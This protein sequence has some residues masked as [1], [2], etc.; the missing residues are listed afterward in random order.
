MILTVTLNASLDKAY[1]VSDFETGNVIRVKDVVC[2]AGGKGLNVARVVKALDEDVLAT[3]F[4]GGY[5]GKFIA[6]KLDDENI[7]HEFVNVKGETRSCL[8]IIDTSTGKH[9]E[10][11]EPGPKVFKDEIQNFITLYEKLVKRSS[12]VTLSGSVPRGVDTSIYKK[13]IIIA[14]NSNKKVILDTSDKLLIEGLKAC[15]TMIKPNRSEAESILK[16]KL[17][18]TKEVAEAARRLLSKGPEIVAISIGSKGVV[19]ATCDNVLLAK[20]PNITAKNTVG[21]GDAMIAGF[22]VGFKKG[23]DIKKS[24]QLAVSVSAASALE[25]ETGGIDVKKA[26]KLFDKVHFKKLGVL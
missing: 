16:K 19:V 20:P 4:L 12:I 23:L 22:A 11:L 2:T 13:L 7:C 17:E 9:T 10:L 21:C 1:I 6:E 24:T 8:N 25:E 3:G 5:Q 18:S 26:K 15:P 14:K